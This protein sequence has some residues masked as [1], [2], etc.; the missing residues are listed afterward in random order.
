MTEIR[1]PVAGF[2]G[3]VVGVVFSGGVGHTDNENALNYFRRHGYTVGAVEGE[4]TVPT[5]LVDMTAAQL[6]VY[7]KEHGI[8]LAGAKKK[9]EILAILEAPENPPADTG[10]GGG[11]Q[12]EPADPAG[13]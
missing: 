9:A 3:E 1:T 13:D 7:A 8:K 2:S 11:E 6:R 5:S 12:T 10:D 4:D